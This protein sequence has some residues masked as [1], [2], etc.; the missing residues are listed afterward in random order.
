MERKKAFYESLKQ[1]KAISDEQVVKTKG[2]ILKLTGLSKD[3][4]FSD[5]KEELS[6]HSA[7]AFVSLVNDQSEVRKE[8][9]AA[10]TNMLNL[11]GY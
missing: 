1:K 9:Q 11:L 10:G 3:T 4:K 7:V 2:A 6:K 5:I 8:A